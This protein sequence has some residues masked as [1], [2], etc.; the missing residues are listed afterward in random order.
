MLTKIFPFA[1]FRT[2]IYFGHKIKLR[3]IYFSE[4]AY[5]L[6]TENIPMAEVCRLE[7]IMEQ[8]PFGPSF[9]SKNALRESFVSIR[10]PGYGSFYANQL[11]SHPEQKLE[12]MS[13][14]IPRAEKY[15]YFVVEENPDDSYTVVADFTAEASG[16]VRVR[17]QN[18]FLEF[19]SRSDE[20][21][22]VKPRSVVVT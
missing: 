18:G 2:V 10:F 4:V 13:V 1:I 6:D 9:A 21:I 3:K 19:L 5:S 11:H 16:V 20:V 15:R 17:E 12:L 22:F 14:V 7:K 8:V